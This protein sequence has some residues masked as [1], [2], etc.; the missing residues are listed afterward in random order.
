MQREIVQ[1][2]KEGRLLSARSPSEPISTL[3]P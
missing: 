2:P 3:G 1:Q